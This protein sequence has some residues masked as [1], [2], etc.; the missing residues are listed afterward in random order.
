MGIISKRELWKGCGLSLEFYD[1]NRKLL[2]FKKD[3]STFSIGN[4]CKIIE[5]IH[6]KDYFH[7]IPE[8]N[9]CFIIRQDSVM[10]FNCETNL[11]EKLKKSIDDIDKWEIN[12]P[13][14]WKEL[15]FSPVE[16]YLDNEQYQKFRK[17]RKNTFAN[18]I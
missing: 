10:I 17:G 13:F 9:K 18:N 11:E 8:S 6:L 7:K 2:S 3:T 14:E 1:R 16:K 12:E 15:P 5:Q 4:D